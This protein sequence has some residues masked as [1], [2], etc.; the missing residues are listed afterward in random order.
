MAAWAGTGTGKADPP[1][2]ACRL[3]SSRRPGRGAVTSRFSS[4]DTTILGTGGPDGSP[5]TKMGTHI[6][7]ESN[8]GNPALIIP[9]PPRRPAIDPRLFT[10][11]ASP[12][13]LIQTFLTSK[14]CASNLALPDL[15]P[16]LLIC[17]F[18]LAKFKF[19]I[20]KWRLCGLSQVQTRTW[21][22]IFGGVAGPALAQAGPA[23][24]S[25]THLLHGRWPEAQPGRAGRWRVVRRVQLQ[26]V[27][28]TSVVGAK[29]TCVNIETCCCTIL[30]WTD[31]RPG[32]VETKSNKN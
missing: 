5:S 32:W 1:V 14:T 6:S 17:Y 23:E 24:R 27:Q 29:I 13:P 30:C 26:N 7:P 18:A 10:T 11:S 31:R 19:G 8:S 21:H 3:R 9:L 20:E 4:R 28:G 25:Q 2:P 16:N 12:T 15:S 22:W